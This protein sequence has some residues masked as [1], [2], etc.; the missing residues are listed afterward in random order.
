M[1]PH[2]HCQPFP[3]RLVHE[4]LTHH[5]TQNEILSLNWS[6][7]LPSS[8]LFS[9]RSSSISDRGLQYS[10]L[11][12]PFHKPINKDPC[13]LFSNVS[14]LLS[15]QV[16]WTCDWHG[17]ECYSMSDLDFASFSLA[18]VPQ[19]PRGY[20]WQP[21]LKGEP[22]PHSSLLFI[23]LHYICQYRHKMHFTYYI[24]I[25]SPPPH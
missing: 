17:L 19:H 14:R 16:L 21:Y 5:H 9:L 3:L 20:S 15:L 2:P 25:V 10:A 6:T 11:H 8:S 4:I 18:S 1:P 7:P 24:I 22:S 12:K 13:D 23:F